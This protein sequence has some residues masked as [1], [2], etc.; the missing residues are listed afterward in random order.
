MNTK[1]TYFRNEPLINR[2]KEM[3]FVKD[4]FSKQPKRILWIYG[5]K[6]TGKTTLIEY[7][8]ENKLF[9]DF[10]LFKSSKYNVKY[11]NFRRSTIGNYDNF[12]N[13]MLLIDDN[14]LNEKLKLSFSLSMFKIEYELYQQVKNRQI[15][16]F[17]TLIK[18]LQNSK[19]RN[20]L[21]FD[22]IQVLQDIYKWR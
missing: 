14:K 20:V 13:S 11:V 8:V 16:L 18:Q 17:D 10:K 6:S 21:I 1:T 19:K 15:N 12:I 3:K 2:K 22:E 9:D 5:P 4:F 7:I